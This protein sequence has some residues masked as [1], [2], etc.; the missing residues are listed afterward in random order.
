[1]QPGY[2][3]FRL[4]TAGLGNGLHLVVIRAATGRET[5]KVLI[6]K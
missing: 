4:R 1:V 2:N 5:G 6:A 3:Q